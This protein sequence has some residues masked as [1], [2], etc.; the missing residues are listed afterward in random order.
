MKE[1]DKVVQK[2]IRDSNQQ[3]ITLE[4]LDA[5]MKAWMMLTV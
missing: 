1:N 2:A 3:L 4:A 5:A